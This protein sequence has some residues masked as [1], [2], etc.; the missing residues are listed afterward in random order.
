MNQF[1]REIVR[2]SVAGARVTS[3][4][5]QRLEYIDEAGQAWSIDL[6][7]CARNWVQYHD[8]NKQDFRLTCGASTESAA[9]WNLRCV[10][11]RD[12]SDNPPWVEFMNDRRT[13]FQFESFEAVYQHLLGRL[14]EVGWHT[15][16]LS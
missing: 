8:D 11:E 14:A 15:F 3:V 12:A 7:Q 1:A 16:D 5:Q 9:Q 13:R 6:E 10:G 4:T 2:I